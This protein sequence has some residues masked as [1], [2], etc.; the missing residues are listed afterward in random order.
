MGQ[1]HA[2]EFVS[3]LRSIAMINTKIVAP[4]NEVTNAIQCFPRVGE[5]LGNGSGF[6]LGRETVSAHGDHGCASGHYLLIPSNL[7]YS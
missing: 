6:A 4:I 1:I 2:Q 3:H 7:K 5:L